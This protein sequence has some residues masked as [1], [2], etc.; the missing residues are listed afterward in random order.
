MK[1]ALS[2]LP[3]HNYQKKIKKTSFWTS[4]TEVL[5][6]VTDLGGIVTKK[7]RKPKLLTSTNSSTQKSW[8]KTHHCS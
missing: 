1:I 5:P 2:D 4:Q 3:N 7:H 6:L 8:K